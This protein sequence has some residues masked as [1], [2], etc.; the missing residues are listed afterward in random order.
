MTKPV[1][2]IA[3]AVD[4]NPL[5]QNPDC[6]T[7]IEQHAGHAFDVFCDR[8]IEPG[9]D[10]ND[11]LE[12]KVEEAKAA[13]L[14]IGPNFL[15]SKYIF[16]KELPGLSQKKICIPILV[17]PAAT[18]GIK[19]NPKGNEEK[20]E[21]ENMQFHPN[22]RDHFYGKSFDDRDSLIRDL[23]VKLKEGFEGEYEF[24]K[25]GRK[26][27]N[28]DNVARD[29]HYVKE[30][31]RCWDDPEIHIL[32]IHGAPGVGKS[33][34]IKKWISEHRDE[35]G[36]NVF[37]YSFA[38]E[39]F[40]TPAYPIEGRTEWLKKL[41]NAGEI[42]GD[43]QEQ[44]PEN[45]IDLLA[46]ELVTKGGVLRLDNTELVVKCFH[47]TDQSCTINNKALL[48]FIRIYKRKIT[49][50]YGKGQKC[51]LILE[52]SLPI[53][54]TGDNK[55]VEKIFV[56][57]LTPN[58]GA[59][60]LKEY[61]NTYSKIEKLSKKSSD[62]Y[63]RVSDE[64]AGNAY[65][66]K[67]L[68]DSLLNNE[69]RGK[70][71]R[72]LLLPLETTERFAQRIK[73]WYE[74]L[75]FSSYQSGNTC[76]DEL[77]LGDARR[78]LSLIALFPGP[79]DLR[80][81]Q[82]V[83]DSGPLEGL[84]DFEGVH[85]I[86]SFGKTLQGLKKFHFIT[87][88]SRSSFPRYQVPPLLKEVFLRNSCV[89]EESLRSAHKILFKVCLESLPAKIE[90]REELIQCAQTVYHGSEAGL[91][92]D[93]F[94]K[95]C[96]EILGIGK[97]I[98]DNTVLSCRNLDNIP[99][100]EGIIIHATNILLWT[101]QCFF[102]SGDFSKLKEGKE[103]NELTDNDCV[104]IVRTAATLLTS[105]KGYGHHSVNKIYKYA[106]ELAKVNSVDNKESFLAYRGRLTYLLSRAKLN[107]DETKNLLNRLE[108]TLEV[109]KTPSARAEL[110]FIKGGIIFYSGKFKEA[111]LLFSE[112][113]CQDGNGR[114]PKDLPTTDHDAT[115]A[116]YCYSAWAATISGCG[117]E[118]VRDWYSAYQLA[119]SLEHAPSVALA[120]HFGAIIHDLMGHVGLMRFWAKEE[121]K[122]AKNYDFPL[123]QAGAN[124]Y[125][126]LAK[127][128]EPNKT[129]DHY[130]TFYSTI[131]E[132][133][134]S[135]EEW[136]NTG[137]M[138]GKTGYLVTLAFLAF[139]HL[140]DKKECLKKITEAE[141]IMQ[142]TG[143]RFCEAELLR[144]KAHLENSRDLFKKAADVARNQGAYLFE[145]RAL[146][147]IANYSEDCDSELLGL[148]DTCSK[149]FTG[150]MK[151]YQNA[152]S[153][154]KDNKDKKIEREPIG[155]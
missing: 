9:K 72:R 16:E 154:L 141:K 145:L 76:Q 30:I 33:S 56:E 118:C 153:L 144:L 139:A 46:K 88:S 54:L 100:S 97:G 35:T 128:L 74:H 49:E 39:K 65:S 108:S 53:S 6:I 155:V 90:L 52:S 80:H 86:E 136:T 96:V 36:N 137:T 61:R 45:Q 43:F 19:Y 102:S 129:K 119:C 142:E 127:V 95:V 41:D 68:A 138:V 87:E 40:S 5:D 47:S 98:Y 84:T 113:N 151:V 115:V 48:A 32:V 75:I 1:L 131:D 110:S 148:I 17:R 150:T 29:R 93:S 130:E 44:N 34:S 64:Y 91:L 63:H 133:N 70:I 3:Y 66:L 114:I 24:G 23:V 81:I 89:P 125:I 78:A 105:I 4:D 2:F 82:K 28:T 20:Q 37:Y 51:L 12:K 106:E 111:R 13:V 71:E 121:K 107:K 57:P 123:W 11:V 77:L 147:D 21:L 8:K 116:C 42:D 103:G 55:G 7:L 92:A 83:I 58:Q 99:N 135:Y 79:A 59:K 85:R 25:N 124:F 50:N 109:I 31:Q 15:K 27:N 146:L 126:G 140:G 62:E 73:N 38:K 152:I 143:E 18:K 117:H 101:L 10:W 14:L 94:N 134:T 132:M 22:N 120:L 122:L 104:Q 60:L 67:L 149:R 69:Y 112:W 26:Y